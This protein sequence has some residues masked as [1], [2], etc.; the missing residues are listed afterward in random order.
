MLGILI[1]DDALSKAN[2]PR[3]SSANRGV[4][5]CVYTVYISVCV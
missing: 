3:V 5:V 2:F 1:L 4:C